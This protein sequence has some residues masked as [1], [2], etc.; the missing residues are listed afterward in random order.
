MIIE[1]QQTALFIAVLSVTIPSLLKGLD[2]EAPH[3]IKT[4]TLVTLFLS[5]MAVIVTTFMRIWT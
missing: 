4:I 1:I 2:K 3:W 5:V